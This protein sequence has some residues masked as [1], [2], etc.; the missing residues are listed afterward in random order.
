MAS[1]TKQIYAISIA[2][3]S[4]I[5][6]IPATAQ[7]DS[8]FDVFFD[9]ELTADGSPSQSPLDLTATVDMK[10][11]GGES[12]TFDTEILS[13]D[14]SSSS[15][16][17][18]SGGIGKGKRYTAMVKYRVMNI[19]SSGLDGVRFV[20]MIIVCDPSCSIISTRAM[21]KKTI[22]LMSRYLNRHNTVYFY[23]PP[24]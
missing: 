19:G 12:R 23:Y 1:L 17:P 5:V 2:I 9:I 8:L 15:T 20:E 7:P 14:L 6:S 16:L 18:T 4:L 22:E 13:M 24:A 21:T 3:C 10:S 11:R